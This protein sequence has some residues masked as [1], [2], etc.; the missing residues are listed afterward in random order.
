MS[1]VA[2]DP[3]PGT[4]DAEPSP[5]GHH[6]SKV[7]MEVRFEHSLNL[8]PLLT[9]LGTSL[10][11]ST[12]QAGKLAVVGANQGEFVLSFHNFE[13]AMGIAVKQDRIALGTTTQIWFLRAAHEI[14]PG[15]EPIGRHDGCFL[16][17]GLRTSPARSRPTRWPG[18]TIGSGSST[19]RSPA[20]ARSTTATVSCRAG[21][22]TGGSSA[23]RDRSA[24]LVAENRRDECVSSPRRWHS[25][26]ISDPTACCRSA[27]GGVTSPSLNR[28]SVLCTRRTIC[29]PGKVPRQVAVPQINGVAPS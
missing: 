9:H 16:T 22:V 11:V 26:T 14:A 2:T 13:R 25:L 1:L 4:S 19:A 24:K 15:M 29:A 18:R 5:H 28:R 12:Y 6:A 10:L 20:S 21:G 3:M 7:P 8:A 17:P 23:E 27:L